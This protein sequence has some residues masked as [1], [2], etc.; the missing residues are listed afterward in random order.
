MGE[1]GYHFV[2]IA[3][4]ISSL[5]LVCSM[6]ALLLHHST[7]LCLFTVSMFYGGS[8]SSLFLLRCVCVDVCR[9]T[10]PVQQSGA[11]VWEGTVSNRVLLRFW[12]G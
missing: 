12:L 8:G 4:S 3:H 9:G 11:S 5:H 6:V 2:S 1:R 7:P 10:S